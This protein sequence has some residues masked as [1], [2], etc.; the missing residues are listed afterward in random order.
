MIQIQAGPA[1]YFSPSHPDRLWGPLSILSNRR[2]VERTSPSIAR[3]REKDRQRDRQT[4]RQTARQRNILFKGCLTD[5]NSTL[6]R[7]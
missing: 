7:F 5:A 2:K 4:D 6:R 1:E 3:R